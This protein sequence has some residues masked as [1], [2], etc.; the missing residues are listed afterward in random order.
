MK[1]YSKHILLSILIT[2]LLTGSLFSHCE[3]P[4]GI[5]NDEIRIN[6]LQEH[7]TTIEKSMNKITAISSEKKI[8]N[9]QLIRWVTN[10]EDHAKKFQDIVYQYFMTQRI[11]LVDQ[12][13]EKKYSQYT[14]K[15]I[16]LHE[17]LVY[18][19]KAKQSVNLDH[20]NKL[21]KLVEEF[22]KVYFKNKGK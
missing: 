5:Y 12:K 20:I 17:M 15:L 9:N 8:D 7:I 11:P 18:A 19:M 14:Q 16:L 21:R 4:C 13:D 2:L 22:R 10:K 6:L 3:I 1:N